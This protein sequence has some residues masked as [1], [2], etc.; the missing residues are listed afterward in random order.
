[1]A[2]RMAMAAGML[3][4]AHVA[5]AFQRETIS[6]AT[7][8]GPN[9]AVYVPDAIAGNAKTDQKLSLVLELSGR[10][11]SGAAI[12]RAMNFRDLVDSEHF[13]WSILGRERWNVWDL[14]RH[15]GLVSQDLQSGFMPSA[16]VLAT[17]WSSEMPPA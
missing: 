15:I 12:E 5:H 2:M 6:I 11:Q 14:R 3:A 7:Y 8:D 16:S 10:C 17:C 13:V 1:M 4:V 9:A